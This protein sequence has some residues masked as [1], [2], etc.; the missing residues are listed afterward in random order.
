MDSIDQRL[1]LRQGGLSIE[2]YV[3]RFCELSFQVPLYNKFLFK[4]LFYFGLNRHI[5][6]LFHES[7][8]PGGEFNGSLRGLMDCAL[9]YAGSLFTVGVAVEERNTVSETEVAD[10]PE[11]THKMAATATG[12]IT[13]A[14]HES[15]KVTASH[16]EPNQV[17]ADLPEPHNR[18]AKPESVHISADLSESLHVSADLPDSLH[19]STDLPEP[20]P[21]QEL[22][23]SAPQ[24][25]CWFRP[26]PHSPC[27]FRPA[28]QSPCWFLP[29]P[30]SPCW[31][32]LAPQS[33]CWFF[34]AP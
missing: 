13:T 28:P 3:H 30:Q 29:V 6:S 27:W 15:G 1:H 2:E 25:P 4:D 14:I 10:A 34:P 31:F 8:F 23:E 16:C 18:P 24:S 9:L 19:V 22:T 26:A 11:R 17:N 20:A 12:H 5:K 33:P 7:L 32:L 21:S